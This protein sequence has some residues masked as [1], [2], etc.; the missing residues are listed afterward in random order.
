[1][2]FMSAHNLLYKHQYGFRAS[3]G[4]SH[5]RIHFTEKFYKSLNN[6]PSLFNMSVFIDLKKAFDTVNFDILLRK[7]EH[8][9]VRNTENE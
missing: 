9:G 7:L 2:G 5:P 6:S 3:H 4:T 8:H 1:M